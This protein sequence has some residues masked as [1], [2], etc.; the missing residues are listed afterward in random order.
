MTRIARFLHGQHLD[1]A[2]CCNVAHGDTR[3]T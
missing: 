3:Q 1:L 2:K